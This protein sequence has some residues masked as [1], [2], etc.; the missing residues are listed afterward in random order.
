MS[1]EKSSANLL[2]TI[3][4]GLQNGE[5][6]MYLQFIVDNKTKG[7]VSAEALSRWETADGVVSPGKYIRAMEDSGLI[8][9]LD[10]RMFE[11]ACR[12]LSEWARTERGAIS[13]SCNFTRITISDADFA[14]K[15]REIAD[16][17][18][19]ERHKLIVE[20]TE[21]SMERNFEA[22]KENIVAAK[23]LGFT[24]ALDDV[25]NGYTPLRNLCDY[26]IDVVKLDRALLLLTDTERG[27]KLF[28]GVISL[29]HSLDLTLV[30]EG[31]ETEEQNEFVSASGCDLIQG[32]Y[33]STALPEVEAEAFAR[34][35][36]HKI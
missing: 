7:I 12:K 10:Y 16:K 11:N 6:K 22:A 21:D 29:M 33:Y 26:P 24:V 19:F 25:G 1:I 13:I 30:C 3:E 18:S 8:T 2:K 32:W 34:A 5:F 23:A 35:Y 28:Y 27:R 15:I 17:Y 9:V 31:V 36:T 14:D 20:I 4:N